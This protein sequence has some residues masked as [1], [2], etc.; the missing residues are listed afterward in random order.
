MDVNAF[1]PSPA[2]QQAP[3]PSPSLLLQYRGV[4]ETVMAA[5]TLPEAPSFLFLEKKNVVAAHVRF[6]PNYR[7]TMTNYYIAV[8][9]NFVTD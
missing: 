4:R 1:T 2:M 3:P 8:L 9:Q 5:S 6:P 7:Q